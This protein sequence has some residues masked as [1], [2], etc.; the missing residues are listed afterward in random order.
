M[1][2]HRVVLPGRSGWSRAC[3]RLHVRG[4]ALLCRAR[5]RFCCG[6]E[7]VRGISHYLYHRTAHS[8]VLPLGTSPAAVVP[9]T[10]AGASYGDQ[11]RNGCRAWNRAGRLGLDREPVGQG[12]PDGRSVLRHQAEHDQRRAS[13]VVSGIGA[14]GQGLRVVLHQLHHRSKDAGQVQRIVERAHLSGEGVQGNAGELAVREPDSLRQRWNGDHPR[15][16]RSASEAL[17]NRWSRYPTGSFRIGKGD[18]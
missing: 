14:S 8:R 7:N 11:S 5:A 18:V 15:L 1:Y 10:V 12:S 17:G 3:S 16:F 9:R 2:V 13:M 6:C 4:V